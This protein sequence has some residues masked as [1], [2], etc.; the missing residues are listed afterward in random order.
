MRVPTLAG[1][2]AFDYNASCTFRGA[3]L[4]P[5]SFNKSLSVSETHEGIQGR[6][7]T[8]RFGSSLLEDLLHYYYYGFVH[9]NLYTA[10]RPIFCT[11]IRL[12]LLKPKALRQP[13]VPIQQL[14]HR[15]MACHPAQSLSPQSSLLHPYHQGLHRKRR[16]CDQD[17]VWKRSG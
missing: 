1:Q 12:S 14:R 17:A 7:C 2:L 3:R 16:A 6:L 5:K 13:A 8:Y 15:S 11:D 9:R 10:D 4:L